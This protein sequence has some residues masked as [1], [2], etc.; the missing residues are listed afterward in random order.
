MIKAFRSKS[1]TYLSSNT[2]ITNKKFAFNDP[3]HSRV[4][5]VGVGF[6]GLQ[7]IGHL[8]EITSTI[9]HHHIKAFDYKTYSYYT[10]GYDYVPYFLKTQEELE[11]PT[12]QILNTRT[13]INFNEI[14]QI[15]PE[16]NQVV[17]ADSREYQ[18]DYLI[19]TTG[20]EPKYNS[21]KGYAEAL[22]DPDCPVFSCFD[23]KSA[24]KAR[25]DI[26]FFSRGTAIFYNHNK[27]KTFYSGIN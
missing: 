22:N 13:H 25:R 15:N 21:I 11:R 5:L 12:L 24:L 3:N 16:K 23:I 7:V 1:L 4:A 27:A 8:P 9:A 17:T 18:Y 14:E 10:P 26:E 2:F 20:L 6:S 19:L